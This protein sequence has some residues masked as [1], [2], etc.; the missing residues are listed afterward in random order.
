MFHTSGMENTVCVQ[1]VQLG[2]EAVL[3]P[4]EKTPRLL[5]GL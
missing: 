2:V 4:E 5:S 3:S 1:Y